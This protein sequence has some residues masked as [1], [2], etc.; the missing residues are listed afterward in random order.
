MPLSPSR[1]APRSHQTPTLQGRY[2]VFAVHG[3]TYAVEASCVKH[4]RRGEGVVD[5]ELMFLGVPYAVIDLRA[6]LGFPGWSGAAD[7]PHGRV[8]VLVAGAGH[9][10][11]L[12]VDAIVNL[13]LLPLDVIGSVPLHFSAPERRWFRGLARVDGCEVP[14]LDVEALLPFRLERRYAQGLAG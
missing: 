11:A 14:V 1:F 5:G 7:G 8:A 4:V 10:G 12:L 6:L 3:R 2:L 13:I 9:S